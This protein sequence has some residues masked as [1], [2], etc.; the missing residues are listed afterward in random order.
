[1]VSRLS[2]IALVLAA[3][4][5]SSGGDQGDPGNPVPDALVTYGQPYTG[6]QFNLGPGGHD[7]HLPS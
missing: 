7:K 3:C 2:A 4:G 6:G 1:M 5:A